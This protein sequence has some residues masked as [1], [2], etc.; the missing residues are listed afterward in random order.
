MQF[1]HWIKAARQRG[2][3]ATLPLVLPVTSLGLF[4]RAPLSPGYRTQDGISGEW[5]EIKW[6]VESSKFRGAPTS[7]NQLFELK[8]KLFLKMRWRFPLKTLASL[9]QFF[10]NINYSSPG[11]SKFKK[12]E[13]HNSLFIINKSTVFIVNVRTCTC[14][15]Y[16]QWKS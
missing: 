11:G 10:L 7:A 14:S 9:T 15:M 13:S 2:R 12:I 16:H 5:A 8:K 3:G 6:N 1:Y 4:P